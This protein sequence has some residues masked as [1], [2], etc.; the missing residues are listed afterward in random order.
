[1]DGPNP[2]KSYDDLYQTEF[3]ELILTRVVKERPRETKIE[4]DG[5]RKAVAALAF[6]TV[7]IL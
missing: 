6:A 2:I 1:M 4:R 7:F 3:D 5:N